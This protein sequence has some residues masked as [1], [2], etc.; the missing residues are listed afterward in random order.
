MGGIEWTVAESQHLFLVTLEQYGYLR[1]RG[2]IVVTMPVLEIKKKKL[3]L[4]MWTVHTNGAV[5]G[6]V[7][8]WN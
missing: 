3:R 7:T 1:K 2:I 6:E 4:V 8:I 5:S